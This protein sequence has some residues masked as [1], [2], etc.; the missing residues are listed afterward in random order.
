[1]KKPLIK[2][3][4]WKTGEK[5]EYE[6]SFS[7]PS[8]SPSGVFCPFDGAEIIRWYD[9]MSKGYECPAC[10]IPYDGMR[11]NNQEEANRVANNHIKDLGQRLE[12]LNEEK[13]NI[14]LF[15]KHARSKGLEN[16]SDKELHEKN[17]HQPGCSY[18]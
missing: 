15:L 11:R 16:A 18:C 5:L 10:S 17:F 3:K 4:D 8:E 14:K 12:K 9:H 2:Y 1:M 7:H 13:N 6:L